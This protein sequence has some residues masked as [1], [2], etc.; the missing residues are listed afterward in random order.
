MPGLTIV[1]SHTIENGGILPEVA[2]HSFYH[3][4]VADAN[5]DL[6]KYSGYLKSQLFFMGKLIAAMLRK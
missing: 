3:R 5:D 4:R 2:F 6:P 1:P